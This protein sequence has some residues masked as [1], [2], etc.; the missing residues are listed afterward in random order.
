MSADTKPGPKIV[1]KPLTLA[2]LMVEM[3]REDTD[4]TEISELAPL[5]EAVPIRRT[6]RLTPVADLGSLA[7]LWELI[8]E[9]NSG[10]TMLARWMADKIIHRG[11]GSDSAIVTLAPGNRNLSQF[12]GAVMQPPTS[13]PKNTAV[14]ARKVMLAMAS[15]RRSGL[16]DYGGGDASKR[17]LIQS[18]PNL[19]D[20]MEEAGLALVACYALTPRPADLT[21]LKTYEAMG[22]KPRATALA[23]NLA[24]AETPA[25][26]DGLRRQP[27]Y[28]AAIARGAVE[29]W[30]PAMPQ[31]V[32]LRI[33]RAQVHFTQ[34][35]D[36]AA[37]E[38]RKPANLT[39]FERMA[40]SEWLEAMDA[41]FRDVEGWL[42]WG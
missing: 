37:P 26:F 16:F 9:G 23:L 2:A 15:G 32:A 19:A 34:A 11:L 14:F 13:D 4:T 38:G 12:V 31:D 41:E 24:R 17:H 27:E 6:P 18:V 20:V 8:G 25:A 3:D 36:G 28:K 7:R 40:V 5:L 35:R 10:K 42:P 39:P 21:F 29:L 1:P 30:I 33:E 22:F